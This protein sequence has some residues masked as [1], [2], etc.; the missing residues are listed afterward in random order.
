METKQSYARTPDAL[1]N[2]IM[3]A[4]D[5]ADASAAHQLLTQF[6]GIPL[7]VKV[8]MELFYAEGPALVRELKAQGFSIFLDLKLHDIPNTVRSAA[9]N[10]AKLGVDVFNVHAA[11]GSAM[12]QAAK[13]GLEEGWSGE[14]TKPKLIAVTMLTSTNQE[15]MNREIGIPCAVQDIVL[16]YAKMAQ[17]CGLDGVVSSA[18]EV[19]S[20]KEAC[21]E[22]FLTVTPGI[23]PAGVDA[24]D[25]QRVM[26]PAEAIQ[27]GVD[28]LV[29]G[30]AI[31]KAEHP[32]ETVLAILKE[33]AEA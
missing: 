30:R 25:Q 19:Q 26:T 18:Q 11:G 10:I 22:S 17:Q 4:L 5:V 33:M 31:T 13:Q 12:M 9:R 7:T 32:R 14:G 27:A 20:I 28:Y 1:A 8:G 24:N 2:R 6:A 16:H 23:R 29:I 3:L 15:V 21:G